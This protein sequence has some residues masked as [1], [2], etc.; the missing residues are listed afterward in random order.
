MQNPYGSY[1][2][3]PLVAPSMPRRRGRRGCVRGCLGLTAVIGVVLVL[4]AIVSRFVP[5][6]YLVF[7]NPLP[8]YFQYSH[9]VHPG[10]TQV[11]RVAWSPDGA[12]V[13]SVSDTRTVQVWRAATGQ[14][15][16]TYQAP[17]NS[18]TISLAWSPDGKQ[19]ALSDTEHAVL[20]LAAVSGQT[21]FAVPTSASAGHA[22]A[23]SP[24]STAIAAINQDG[25]IQVWKVATSQTLLTLSSIRAD[26]VAWSP[27]GAYLASTGQDGAMRI[28]DAANGQLLVTR[29]A[30]SKY[31]LTSAPMWSVDSR[32]IAFQL[33]TLENESVEV[34]NVAT[35][36]Q[37]FAYTLAKNRV[38]RLLVAWSP[39]SDHL[40]IAGELGSSISIWD[41]PTDHQLVSYGGHSTA[42]ILF[43]S[44]SAVEPLGVL[45]LAW[46][47]DGTRIVSAGSEGS[48]QIWDAAS[49]TTLFVLYSADNSLYYGSLQGIAAVAWSP[50][51]TREV[52]GC[53]KD[54]EIW[55]PTA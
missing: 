28:W 3:R 41:V 7:L 55:Q 16:F 9:L 35:H 29:S 17:A 38:N 20:V 49:G 32:E 39:T 11:Y 50:D 2:Q 45:A 18:A 8:Y 10:Q 44:G 54:A 22:I 48:A 42:A 15:R 23:W 25:H 1:P 34:W 21:V 5:I 31:D 36:R 26:E 51:G 30:P 14:T 53:G 43:A 52:L 47:P 6:P 24:D 37:V 19:L 33:H 4:L 13:A 40:A 46:S 12:D 27:N